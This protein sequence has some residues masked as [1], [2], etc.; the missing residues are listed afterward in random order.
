M[1]LRIVVPDGALRAPSLELLGRRRVC[2]RQSPCPRAVAGHGL[3]AGE[4]RAAAEGR[5][6]ADL[7]VRLSVVAA[8]DVPAYLSS[9]AADAGLVA[10]DA[11]LEHATRLCELLD[12]RFGAGQL[13]YAVAPGA[14]VRCR[15]ARPPAHRHPAPGPDALVPSR[16]R[17]A[18]EHRPG[19]RHARPGRLRRPRRRRRHACRD[20]PDGARA[21]GR[22]GPTV[23]GVVAETSI[24]LVAGRG[25]R[26][27]HGAELGVLVAGLRDLLAG[28]TR[29][30]RRPTALAG[31][32]PGR[33][34]TRLG[35]GA[36]KRLTLGDDPAVVVAALRDPP[37]VELAVEHVVRAILADVARPRRRRRARRRQT[38]R[39]RRAARG[40]GLEPA[41][42]RAALAAAAP[43]LRAALELAAANI[44]AYHT[45]E[46][47]APWRETLA[48]GQVVGQE[49]VPL[50]VAGLYV[51]GGLANYPSSVL[52]T[53]IPAQVA[54]VPRVVVCSPPRARRRRRRG[55]RRRLRAARRHRSVPHRRRSG[56]R[57]HGLRHG[58][59]AALRRHR[60]AGERLRHRSQ[61][62]GH[63]RACASTAW[64]DPA[65]C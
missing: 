4:G 39:P 35:R 55:R 49:I 13:V 18:G 2:R 32:A 38:P 57:R 1:T 53:A 12:L 24:R 37:A 46:K 31:P 19:R 10:K 5:T 40:Y 28:G 17:P 44:R 21:G 34:S 22:R 30:E 9:G 62:P 6:A 64:P 11:L 14:E 42:L 63:G 33:R 43:E 36:V 54:G 45:R 20:H 51:P 59:R 52:M 56:G 58:R 25:A 47:P 27:L 7:D 50:G 16:A 48:Q 15:T 65:R 61:A 26:V 60:R 8:A 3:T 41:A 29:H 23:E